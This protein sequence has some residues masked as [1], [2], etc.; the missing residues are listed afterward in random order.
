MP[1]VDMMKLIK[2]LDLKGTHTIARDVS[3]NHSDVNVCMYVCMYM[4]VCVC[5]RDLE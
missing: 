2:D 3:K 4:C 1:S 5:V